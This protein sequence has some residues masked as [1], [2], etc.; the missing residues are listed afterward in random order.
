MMADLFQNLRR[1]ALMPHEALEGQWQFMAQ[2]CCLSLRILG[3]I[4]DLQ[5]RT[6]WT[7]K[8][9]SSLQG[10]LNV[11]IEHHPTI[12]YMVYNGYYK[13][14][15]NI[16]KMGHLPTPGLQDLEVSPKSVVSPL[17]TPSLCSQCP[18]GQKAT[19]K[20]SEDQKKQSRHDLNGRDAIRSAI[21]EQ[22]N[23]RNVLLVYGIL[24]L[25]SSLTD[26]FLMHI[27]GKTNSEKFLLS[28]RNTHHL[29]SSP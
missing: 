1:I 2:R 6:D 17:S 5:A 16:P 8:P 14:M 7:M 21:H 27:I 10:S 18:S 28:F 22:Q 26:E 13:V 25:L 4:L 12:R 9:K 11:P 24:I 19:G 23:P 3:A 29:H 20:E 15:S